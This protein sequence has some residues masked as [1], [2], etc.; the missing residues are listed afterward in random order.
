MSQDRSAYIPL[1]AAPT[2]PTTPPD[3]AASN[4]VIDIP[5]QERVRLLKQVACIVR[6]KNLNALGER[7]GVDGVSTLLRSHSEVETD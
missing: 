7:G 3:A 4:H 2:T 1:L 6:E 5:L